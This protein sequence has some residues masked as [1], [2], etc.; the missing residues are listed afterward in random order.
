[1]VHNIGLGARI[2]DALF[3][4]KITAIIGI[5]S[6]NKIQHIRLA[7]G[8]EVRPSRIDGR[9]CFATVAFKKGR[10]IAEYA[11]ERIP[12]QEVARR[13]K[14]KRRIYICGVDSYWAIDGSTAATAR[15]SSIIPANP[16]CYSKVV[17]NHILFF[18]MRDIE[19]GEG[20]LLDYGESYHSNRKRCLCGYSI[21]PGADQRVNGDILGRRKFSRSLYEHCRTRAEDRDHSG[22]QHSV[23]TRRRIAAGRG[24]ARRRTALRRDHVSHRG[25]VASHRDSLALSP[26]FCE[27]RERC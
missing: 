3:V 9:G 20:S 26:K 5:L 8:T 11:G 19:P 13:L 12:R 16:I 25:A 1:M 18:A 21:V 22:R 4:W 15:N 6:N 24:A 17:H 2:E 27:A 10:K 14:N 7:P 23:E